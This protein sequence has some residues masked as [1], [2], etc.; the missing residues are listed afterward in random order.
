M[1]FWFLDEVFCGQGPMELV[2]EELVARGVTFKNLD[3]YKDDY[4]RVDTALV[5]VY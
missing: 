5:V 4:V 1:I 3:G 2:F